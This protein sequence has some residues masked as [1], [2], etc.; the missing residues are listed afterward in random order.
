MKFATNNN[1]CIY[2][3]F[4]NNRID[5]VRWFN[6]NRLN[7]WNVWTDMCFIVEAGKHSDHHTM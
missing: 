4:I 5:N 1:H 6:D 7:F 3:K 2:L